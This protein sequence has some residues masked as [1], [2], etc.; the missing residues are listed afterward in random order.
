[1]YVTWALSIIGSVVAIYAASSYVRSILSGE[2]KPHRVTWA[3][4]TL[5]G[6]LGF[7][8]SF[9]G[10]ARAGL[11]VTG[12]IVVLNGIVFVISLS[13]KY[14]KPGGRKT[15]YIFGVVAVCGLLAWRFLHFSP[16]VA[17]TIA[18]VS[19][20]VFWWF[21]FREAWLRP[22][23]EKPKPWIFGTVAAAIGFI[24]LGNYSWAAAAY[25]GYILVS[26]AAIVSALLVQNQKRRAKGS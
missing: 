12:A 18:V 4:W 19:D 26:N 14:G 7:S 17:A 25:P 8:A 21:T 11:L 3:G 16:G 22:D 5:A 1:M 23:L 24:T 6:V 2:S 20:G 13:P 9:A 15:D 10:G